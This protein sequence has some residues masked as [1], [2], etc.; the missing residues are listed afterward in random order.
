MIRMRFL[1]FTFLTC[2]LGTALFGASSV[3]ANHNVPNVEKSRVFRAVDDV[4]ID[5]GV[6]LTTVE[7]DIKCIIGNASQ[8]GTKLSISY[9]LSVDSKSENSY[10]IGD[11]REAANLPMLFY[12]EVS[13]VSGQKHSKTFVNQTAKNATNYDIVGKAYARTFSNSVE[14]EIDEGYDFVTE[15][16]AIGNIYKV[17]RAD[18]AARAKG[19]TG[20]MADTSVKYYLDNADWSKAPILKASDFLEMNLARTTS[21]GNYTSIE[22]DYVSHVQENFPILMG[23][24]DGETTP[25]AWHSSYKN[26]PTY[27]ERVK[28]GQLIIHPRF[29][30]IT[31]EM[32]LVCLNKDGETIYNEKITVSD[33]AYTS[34][35]FD[36]TTGKIRFLI[37]NHFTK[38]GPG[39]IYS[40]RIDSPTI[41]FALST[42]EKKDIKESFKTTF[43]QRFTHISVA[44]KDNKAPVYVSV[45]FVLWLTFLILVAVYVGL[46]IWLYFYR[47]E[48]YKNDEFNR[49]D[50]KSWIKSSVIYF[51]TIS[52]MVFDFLFILFRAVSMRNSIVVYNPLDVFIIILS[53]ASIIAIGY[54][55]MKLV[56]HIKNTAEKKK[57][58]ELHLNDNDSDDGTTV[59]QTQK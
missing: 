38:G 29:S 59:T 52:V 48:K 5:K 45:D 46:D 36:A 51:V 9:T 3:N 17:V 50:K 55:V 49:V 26:M 11:Y 24:V 13:D 14:L 54:L 22:C 12:Y 1:K 44:T 21:F 41:T 10:M 39:D 35:P 16:F 57:T 37:E 56:K 30:S 25:C 42:P 28:S 20:Y 27:E 4:E 43:N 7:P 8:N 58:E 19:I 2:L 53:V 32:K 18:D 33:S 31:N 6:D 23:H 47:K 40:F 34:I 15:S